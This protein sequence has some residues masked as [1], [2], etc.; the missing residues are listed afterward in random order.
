MGT[1]LY[2]NSSQFSIKF[3]QTIE[4]NNQYELSLAEIQFPNRYSN[5]LKDEVLVHCYIPETDENSKGKAKLPVSIT[6]TAGLYESIKDFI[7]KSNRTLMPNEA[8]I[9]IYYKKI[10]KLARFKLYQRY[11]EVSVK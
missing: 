9:E 2:N 7:N 5:V 10:S 1:F 8:V 4:V 6:L 3:A 11:I